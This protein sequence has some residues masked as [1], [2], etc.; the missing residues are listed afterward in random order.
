MRLQLQ[1][2][3]RQ[4]IVGSADS[5]VHSHYFGYVLGAVT[6][7]L[8]TTL[9]PQ[10]DSDEK[11]HYILSSLVVFFLSQIPVFLQNTQIYI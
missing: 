9:N 6:A 1:A 10:R 7:V 4:L 11:L 8:D 5:F 2:S 3:C